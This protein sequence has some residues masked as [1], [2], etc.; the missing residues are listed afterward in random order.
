MDFDALLDL[1]AV[2]KTAE[3]K[4]G[5][6]TWEVQGFLDPS[7]IMKIQKEAEA[8]KRLIVDLGEGEEI[9]PEESEVMAYCF[10]SAGLVTEKP[11][12]YEMIVRVSRKTGLDCLNAG[13]R[14]MQLSGL[15]PEDMENKENSVEEEAKND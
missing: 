6:E 8:R 9:R 1:P 3:V 11:V 12:H 4:I 15:I 5:G 13:F 2:T 7:K 10:L 14:V